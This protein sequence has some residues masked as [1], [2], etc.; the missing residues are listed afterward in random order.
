MNATRRSVHRFVLAVRATWRQSLQVRVVATT[1]LLS[2]VVTLAIGFMLMYQVQDGLLDAQQRA[3][4]NDHQV[5]LNTALN[6]LQ[7]TDQPER[8]LDDI[9]ADLTARSGATGLY[10][11]AIL[12]S[13]DDMPGRISGGLTADTVPDRLRE[14]VQAS[15]LRSQFHTY[16]ALSEGGETTPALVVG[17]RLST[18]FELYYVFPLTAEQEMLQLV[19][20]TMIGAAFA[21]ILLLAA[22][23]S[24]VTRQVVTP[25]REAARSAERLSSGDL[26]ERMQVRGE[27]DLARLAESFNDMAWN[28]QEKIQE[29]EELSKVQRQFVSDVSHELRTPLTTIR[30]AGDLLY[31]DRDELDPTM[32][33]SVELLQSQ[34]QRFEELLADLLEISRHDAGAVTLSVET[35]DLRDLVMEAAG[36]A[37]QLAERR[38]ITIQLRLPAEPC[39]ADVDVRRINR[40]LRNLIVNAVEHS[41]NK[42]IVV[43][44]AADAHAVAVAVRDFGVGLR[45][46]EAQLCFDRFWRADPARTRTT[47]GTGLGLSIAKEDAQL[48]G[49]W[50]QAWGSPGK[51]S[52]FRL[53][54]PRTH[55]S[56]LEGSPLPLAPPEIS[57][58]QPAS[59]YQ[60]PV[61][62][63]VDATPSR[64]GEE[65]Q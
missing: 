10:E 9:T 63:D 16:A 42:D 30:M 8:E 2:S 32:A 53:S 56:V 46:E 20:R 14:E 12:S 64:T 24:L 65:A 43:A 15:E 50:L 60:T 18:A 6:E 33:R 26:A 48:H 58:T 28:L 44:A 22:I 37:E 35:A 59:S 38:G 49:G 61:Q 19:E 31:D 45:E 4:Y 29:L 23:A 41:E 36:D 27:D 3:A 54:L 34:L 55:G 47:G 39:T 11:V 17:A 57:L 52:Q 40:I 51:G 1:L 7:N 13:Q 21:L 5:G 25:V 62:V